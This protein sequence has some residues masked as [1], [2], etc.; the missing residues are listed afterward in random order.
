MK[1]IYQWRTGRSCVYKINIHLVF[2]TKYRRGVFTNDLLDR[3]KELFKETCQQMDSELLE[4]NG[5]DN[6]VH[7]LITIPP[8]R[9]IAALVGKLKG[10][11]SY[12]LR[13]EYG[14]LLREKLWGTHLWSPSYCVVSCGGAPLEII[15]SYI[16]NQ[17]GPPN[18]TNIKKSE[19]LLKEKPDFAR[20]A[21][22]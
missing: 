17:R 1:E 13:K 19:A 16:E 4:Y 18:K 3:M 21:Y 7:L 12:Y 20:P 22:E 11:S 9:S 14:E 8:K 6:H 15:K 2:V 5:E 10:K